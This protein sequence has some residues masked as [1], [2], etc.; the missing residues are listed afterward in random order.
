ME[1]PSEI[2]VYSGVAS[3]LNRQKGRH[4]RYRVARERVSLASSREA[5]K[6]GRRHNDVG[7]KRYQ[8][9]SHSRQRVGDEC[10][11]SISISS[12]SQESGDVDAL[13]R[14]PSERGHCRA[15]PN[16]E[17]IPR[18]RTVRPAHSY[19]DICKIVIMR[20]REDVR[21]N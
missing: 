5:S 13:I 10:T 2:M 14:A 18:P 7:P 11:F 3:D 4:W 6:R 20:A 19:R 1:P 12:I 21:E 17:E 9:I 16:F 15:S 8:T